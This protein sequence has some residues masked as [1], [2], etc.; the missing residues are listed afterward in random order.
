MTYRD[1][2]H[3]PTALPNTGPDARLDDP[4]DYCQECDGTGY[5][6]SGRDWP[7]EQRCPECDGTGYTAEARM[8]DAD[9]EANQTDADNDAAWVDEQC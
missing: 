7:T 2:D 4:A 8:T 9:R 5:I 1:P 3:L 6:D